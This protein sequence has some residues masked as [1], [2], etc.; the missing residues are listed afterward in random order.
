MRPQIDNL[1]RKR[2]PMHSRAFGRSPAHTRQ[3]QKDGQH[4][5]D[6]WVEGRQDGRREESERDW[7]S[8][9]RSSWLGRVVEKGPHKFKGP[10]GYRRGISESAHGE[11]AGRGG[12]GSPLVQPRQVQAGEQTRS[13]TEIL[14]AVAG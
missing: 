14:L 5:R 13:G 4:E 9:S 6:P 1:Q 3:K 8:K 10:R 7:G 2:M 11:F 12:P